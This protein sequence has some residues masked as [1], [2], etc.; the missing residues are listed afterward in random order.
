MRIN[1]NAHVANVKLDPQIRMGKIKNS[2]IKETKHSVVEKAPETDSFEKTA[3]VSEKGNKADSGGTMRAFEDLKAIVPDS[4]RE[5]LEKT[6][7]FVETSV[8]VSE[9]VFD[10]VKGITVPVAG[11]MTE[12][13][14]IAE[15]TYNVVSDQTIKTSQM[16]MNTYAQ[17]T[18]TIEN[19]KKAGNEMKV[20]AIDIAEMGTKALVSVSKD[21]LSITGTL[22]M[23]GAKLAALYDNPAKG[24]FGK[25]AG[26]VSTI[27]TTFENIKEPA[28]RVANTL[29]TAYR[30]IKE[31]ALQI[32]DRVL[33]SANDIHT[34]KQNIIKVGEKVQETVLSVSERMSD[35]IET[36]GKLFADAGQEASHAWEINTSAISDIM[37]EYRSIDVYA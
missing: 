13:A 36:I 27:G 30:G 15:D 1:M 10:L 26:T 19:L 22:G 23:A 5:G 14:K 29:T 16:A 7:K 12:S 24:L 18:D 4:M 25:I 33:A 35:S 34:V 31:K 3:V 2:E 8:K 17:M 6:G 32:R 28:K 20:H 11:A 37:T 9:K 21:V